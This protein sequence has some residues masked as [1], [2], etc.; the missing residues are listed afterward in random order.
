MN[1][2]QSQNLFLKVVPFLTIRNSKL[3]TQ[4]DKLETSILFK[5]VDNRVLRNSDE[6]CQGL[7]LRLCGLR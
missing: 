5:T 2:Q 7:Y 3:I 4:G 1:E 6:I